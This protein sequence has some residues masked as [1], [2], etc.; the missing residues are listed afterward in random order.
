[1][2]DKNKIMTQ[3]LLVAAILVVINVISDRFFLRLDFTA[4]KRYT[5]SKATRNI[6]R[7]LEEPVTITAYFT[8]DLPP[9]ISATRRDFKDLLVEYANAS[10]GMVVYEFID[11]NRDPE[12]EQKAFQAGIQPVLVSTREKDEAT[13]KKVFLGALVQMGEESD[14][15]PFLQPGAAM[16]YALS[17]SIKKISI[18]EKPQVALIQGHGEPT[19]AAMQQVMA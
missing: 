11:P 8:E 6:L 15:I 12:T 4:D 1:M 19:P 13:Q 10:R 3:L 5:L 18:Q 17:S 2:K 7:T 9:D 16:E 14:V